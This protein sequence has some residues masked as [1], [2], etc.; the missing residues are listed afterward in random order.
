MTAVTV[1]C[2]F[3]G[4]LLGAGLAV[5]LQTQWRM[6]KVPYLVLITA[7]ACYGAIMAGVLGEAIHDG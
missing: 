6:G 3:L 2:A 4:A 7:L 5:S 1:T